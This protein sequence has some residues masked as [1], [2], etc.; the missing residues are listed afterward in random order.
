[1]DTVKGSKVTVKLADAGTSFTPPVV[2]TVPTGIV[3]VKVPGSLLVTLADTVQPCEGITAPDI[4]SK[5]LDPGVATTTPPKQ[6]VVASAGEAI[7]IPLGN[8][9]TK[10][11]VNVVEP[12][13]LLEIETVRV[14]TVPTVMVLGKNALLTTGSLAAAGEFESRKNQSTDQIISE[15][16]T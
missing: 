6:V 8:V 16:F 9:S 11:V 12:P 3:L 4:S 7:V 1:M 13:M 5:L 15:R 10:F 14:L 2:E